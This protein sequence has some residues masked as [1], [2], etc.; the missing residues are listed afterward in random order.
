MIR[1]PVM[2]GS[3]YHFNYRRRCRPVKNIIIIHPFFFDTLSVS[4]PKF[5]VNASTPA[6]LFTRVVF[7]L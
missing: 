3:Q 5:H 7:V 4:F 1:L 2:T 6:R